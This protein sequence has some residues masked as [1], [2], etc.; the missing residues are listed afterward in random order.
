MDRPVELLLLGNDDR[1]A[2]ALSGTLLA[3][4]WSVDLV[5]SVETAQ[6]MFLSRGGHTLL[7][8]T[9]EVPSGLTQRVIERLREVDP[10][11]PILVFGEDSLRDTR[12]PN[13]HRIRSFHPTSRAGLGAIRRIICVLPMR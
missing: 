10:D 4:G 3:D 7:V 6:D 12:L 5:S 13:V 11:L 8:V 2:R 1:P 9:P